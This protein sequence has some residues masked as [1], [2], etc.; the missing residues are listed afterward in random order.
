MWLVN[1]WL[2]STFLSVS[3]SPYVCI[4]V[5][6]GVCRVVCVCVFF[7]LWLYRAQWPNARKT[8]L[9]KQVHSL[10]SP[11]DV[12]RVRPPQLRQINEAQQLRHLFYADQRSATQTSN[13]SSCSAST[14]S[15][16]SG[17]CR[18]C[19]FAA[20]LPLIQTMK[21]RRDSESFW[22]SNCHTHRVFVFWYESLNDKV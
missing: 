5:C 18:T 6:R 20:A 15:L 7:P 8:E 12:L 3:I 13:L 4:G 14:L 1:I 19:S 21:E 16:T 11:S 17:W 10:E 22:S 2:S 9:F